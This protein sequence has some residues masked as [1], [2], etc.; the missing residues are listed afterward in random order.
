MAPKRP[1]RTSKLTTSQRER[2]RAIDREAQRSIR[3]K[4]KNYIAHLENLVK[5]MEHGDGEADG[6]RDERTRELVTQLRQS[7]EEVRRLREMV[8]G[9]Q[10]LVGGALNT[11][12]LTSTTSTEARS[13]TQTGAGGGS[14]T[15]LT[16]ARDCFPGPPAAVGLTNVYS[17]G[18]KL[19]SL[20][21]NKNLML[22]SGR[23][24]PDDVGPVGPPRAAAILPTSQ[25]PGSRVRPM[26][27]SRLSLKTLSETDAVDVPPCPEPPDRLRLRFEGEMFYY[28]KSVL[29]RALA[30]GPGAFINQPF[31]EDIVVRAVLY[32]WP[33]VQEQYGLDIGWQALRGVDQVIFGECGVIERMATLRIMRIRLLHQAQS[34]PAYLPEL[35]NFMRKEAIEK[36]ERLENA[37]IIDHFVWP[38]FRASLHRDPAKYITNHFTTKFRCN[39]KFLWPFDVADAYVRDPTTQLYS[40]SLEFLQRQSNLLCWTMKRDF[41][42]GAEELLEAI[43]TFEAQICR[44]PLPLVPPLEGGVVS[45]NHHLQQQH[46]QQQQRQQLQHQQRQME[47]QQVDESNLENVAGDVSAT[48]PLFQSAAEVHSWLG[49]PTVAPQYWEVGLNSGMGLGYTGQPLGRVK[50]RSSAEW[51][52]PTITRPLLSG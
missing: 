51:G 48:V 2:K 3:T 47:E 35:P 52:S 21:D 1:R 14:Q 22:T 34:D 27:N 26:T 32:G 24:I 7:Q 31:D 43:P 17:T 4:T 9:V 10:K 28:A 6:K 36:S 5:V 37:S 25:E 23:S 11:T 41:F 13:N 30:A 18:S 44:Y 20:P 50:K 45:G 29:D 49:D 12:S 38:G 39:V 19:P 33:T 8:V 40:A 42:N 15:R 46:Q 16:G